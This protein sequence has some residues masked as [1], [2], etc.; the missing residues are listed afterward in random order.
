MHH[1]VYT[2]TTTIL[3]TEAELRQ[4]LAHWRATN[5][6]L[7]ITGVLLYS[8]GQV[9]QVLEGEAPAVHCL[10]A[11]IADD[12]RHRSV[13]KL[14]DGPVDGRAFA[15]WSMRF[16]TVPPA[17]FTRFMLPLASAPEAIGHL[18]ALIQAFMAQ[19]P[20]I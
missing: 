2:S 18:L 20:L 6:R 17:D 8:E 12:A 16:R 1:L 5:T 10:F 11:A 7:G 9:M 14:A 15:D 13:T 19:E 4:L 3:L